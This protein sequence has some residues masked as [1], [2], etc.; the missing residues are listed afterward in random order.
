VTDGQTWLHLQAYATL[1]RNAISAGKQN[2][3]VSKNGNVNIPIHTMRA[4]KAEV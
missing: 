1:L 3:Y 2:N 4:Y